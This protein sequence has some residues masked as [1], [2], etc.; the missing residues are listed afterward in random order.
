MPRRLTPPSTSCT[1]RD[2]SP[3][4]LEDL[5]E[6]FGLIAPILLVEGWKRLA[7]LAF[8][9]ALACWLLQSLSRLRSHLWPPRQGR[10]VQHREPCR[11]QRSW[12]D[13]R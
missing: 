13:L 9:L 4:L 7:L 11:Q 6:I 1:V 5:K 12:S 2:S 8:V 3:Q 10:H